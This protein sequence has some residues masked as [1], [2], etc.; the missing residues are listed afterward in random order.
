MAEIIKKKA[1]VEEKLLKARG[2]MVVRIQSEQILE[3]K[4]RQELVGRF[5]KVK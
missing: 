5:G 3:Q 1:G 2:E 4:L